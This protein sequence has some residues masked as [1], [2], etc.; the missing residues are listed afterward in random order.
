VSVLERL[1]AAGAHTVAITNVGDSPLAQGADAVIDL[2]A[3]EE[4]AVPATKT[5]SAELAA[6]A[7]VAEA[8]GKVPW[9]AADW[10]TL[11]DAAETILNDSQAARDAAWQLVGASGLAVVARGYLYCVA[12]ETALKLKETTSLQA[13][14]YSGADFLH[15]PIATVDEGFPVIVFSVAGPTAPDMAELVHEVRRRGG[16][17]ITIGDE[18]GWAVSL[19][20]GVPEP[21]APIVAVLR[22]QQIAAALAGRLGIDPDTPF[23]LRKVT[24]TR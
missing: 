24:E 20:A 22:G 23:G 12:L 13:Q 7:I 2:G 15:G 16:H 4:R 19:P 18:P 3:G 5:V 17:A 9:S 10:Q 14:G 8:A 21:L 6:F 1:R 11:G